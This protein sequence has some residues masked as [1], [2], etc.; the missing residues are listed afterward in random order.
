M[1]NGR[2]AWQD[3]VAER[4]RA[5]QV[6]SRQRE[7]LQAFHACTCSSLRPLHIFSRRAPSCLR[8]STALSAA[9]TS[10]SLLLSPSQPLP[11]RPSLFQL[12]PS[13]RSARIGTGRQALRAFAI[14]RVRVWSSALCG[15]VH[16]R[17]TASV[18]RYAG[19]EKKADLPGRPA[20]WQDVL[21]RETRINSARPGRPALWHVFPAALATNTGTRL[22]TR[23][24]G[25]A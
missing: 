6:C 14:G 17:T 2:H 19:N 24:G 15:I 5:R 13:S 4:R 10:L 7:M 11:L 20:L 18:R 1:T 23:G 8:L 12:P 21:L 9:H 25:R 3:D 16:W 22:A